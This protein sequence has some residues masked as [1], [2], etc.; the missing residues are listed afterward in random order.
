MTEKELRGIVSD[1]FYMM[2]T[3]LTNIKDILES[4]C[5]NNEDR[6]RLWR[7]CFDAYVSIISWQKEAEKLFNTNEEEL[8]D[9]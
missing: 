4:L 8:E 9:A 5:K 7:G 1:D 3:M 6:E 2:R